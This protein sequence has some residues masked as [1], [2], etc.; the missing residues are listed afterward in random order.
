MF[1][2]GTLSANLLEQIFCGLTVQENNVELLSEVKFA[3]GS[4]IWNRFALKLF[5][6]AL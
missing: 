4:E 5:A 6:A 1:P 3:S 2:R